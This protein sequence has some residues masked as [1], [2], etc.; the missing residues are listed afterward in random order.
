MCQAQYTLPVYAGH[1][2]HTDG[3]QQMQVLLTRAISLQRILRLIF[4]VRRY[5]SAAHAV[6]VCVCVCVSVCHTK[7][8]YQNG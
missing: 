8:L 2:V 4:T 5:A 6:V 1:T 7:V 3:R